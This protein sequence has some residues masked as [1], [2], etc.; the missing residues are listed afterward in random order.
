MYRFF[1]I[2]CCILL[3]TYSVMALKLKANLNDNVSHTELKGLCHPIMVTGNLD[4]T[5]SCEI[6]SLDGISF[7]R[8]ITKPANLEI[9]YATWLEITND[10]DYLLQT[11]PKENTTYIYEQT[12]IKYTW[13][14]TQDL[15]IALYEHDTLVGKFHIYIFDTSAIIDDKLHYIGG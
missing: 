4:G 5:F 10:T 12:T 13:K 2:I 7:H 9:A 14:N 8:Y 15:T 6:C 11:L 3:H 1:I